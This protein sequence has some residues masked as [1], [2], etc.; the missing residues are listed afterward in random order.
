LLDWSL[1]ALAAVC[2]RVVVAVPA[3]MA[4]GPGRVAGGA[5]RSESVKAAMLAEPDAAVYVVQDAAR[6]LV[7]PELVQRCAAAIADG[8]DA[9][10]A[11]APVS[12]TIKQA[13]PDRRVERTLDRSLLWAI[14]TP[15]AFSGQAL[16]R[17]LDVDAATLAAAT[18]DAALV[19]ANG[20]SVTVVEV[21][22]PNLKVT[23]A[24]DLELAEFL[25][26]RC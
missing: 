24:V 1:A 26:A 4:E 12:D 18:D 3:G 22:E 13:G 5:S 6:P 15:Q 23:T 9:A 25:L 17:A 20:G 14:Q 7:T 21:T 8:W 2:D 19:E 11:A 16:R 10:V